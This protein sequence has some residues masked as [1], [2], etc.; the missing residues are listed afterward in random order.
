MAVCKKCGTSFFMSNEEERLLSI[1]KIEEICIE[2]AKKEAKK[3]ESTW[4]PK[5][6]YEY[7]E[8]TDG[9]KLE[10]V[11]FLDEHNRVVK[12]ISLPPPPRKLIRRRYRERPY[13]I[14][15]FV[16]TERQSKRLPT[17]VK[18]ILHSNIASYENEKT[19]WFK[20]IPGFWDPITG[21]DKIEVP[22]ENVKEMIKNDNRIVVKLSNNQS[23]Q[24][25]YK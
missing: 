22:S 8:K 20:K 14:H 4:T 15:A 2:C 7:L 24:I 19:L 17:E 9:T 18:L 12:F 21:V 1:G 11:F 23:L 25:Y 16:I 5:M 3:K 13:E 6:P 10:K